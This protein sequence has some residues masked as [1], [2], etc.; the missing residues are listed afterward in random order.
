MYLCEAAKIHFDKVVCTLEMIWYSTL[1]RDEKAMW[2]DL[3]YE[4]VFL[5][6]L[7]ALNGNSNSNYHKR[8]PCI[9][10][11]SAEASSHYWT[12]QLESQ[13]R[14]KVRQHGCFTLRKGGIGALLCE[15][16]LRR[17]C[18]QAWYLSRQNHCFAADLLLVVRLKAV[19][20]HTGLLAI[21]DG[22]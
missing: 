15:T 16:T 20:S 9:F 1:L 2:F 17:C 14:G 22:L 3:S 12:W 8:L 19:Y 7:T 10:Y 21:C 6:C 18:A 4:D 13:R 5:Y 11:A